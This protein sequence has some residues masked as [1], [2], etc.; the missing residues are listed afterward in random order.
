MQGKEA[1][2]AEPIFGELGDIEIAG[3]QEVTLRGEDPL[4]RSWFWAEDGRTALSLAGWAAETVGEVRRG[5]W[6][7][8]RLGDGA[9]AFE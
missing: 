4:W 5:S 2:D 3:L 6:V 1:C 9:E 7:A 8:A